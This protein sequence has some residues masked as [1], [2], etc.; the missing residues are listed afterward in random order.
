MEI[1][2]PK[3]SALSLLPCFY[4]QLRLH[5]AWIK[6]CSLTGLL[7]NGLLQLELGLPKSKSQ[8]L[9][10]IIS[11]GY[12]GLG[13]QAFFHCFPKCISRNPEEKWSNQHLNWY[14]YGIPLQQVMA[15]M[16]CH[17]TGP[18]IGNFLFSIG[19]K[20]RKTVT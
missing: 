15:C 2:E 17:S 6:N 9:P 11:H 16:L 12:R 20:E 8:E 5:H 19:Y 3:L 1:L 7:P 13:N 18:N 4:L 10:P 14:P